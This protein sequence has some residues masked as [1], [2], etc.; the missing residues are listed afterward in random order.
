MIQVV[1]PGIPFPCPICG[2]DMD[3]KLPYAW[4]HIWVRKRGPVWLFPHVAP[5]PITVGNRWL[6]QAMTE[7]PIMHHI[8]TLR[9]R[10]L[11][12]WYGEPV[13]WVWT[14]EE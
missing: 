8:V 12:R 7:A 10:Q 6:A 3:L 11:L 4:E 9:I 13:E 14:V 5:T 2:H 1:R